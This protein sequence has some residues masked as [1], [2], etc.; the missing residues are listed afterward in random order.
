MQAL[1]FRAL[2][3]GSNLILTRLLFPEAFGLMT[4]VTVFVTGLSMISDVGIRPALIR[5]ARAEDP[6]F[7]STAWSLQILRGLALTALAW[8]LAWPYAAVYDADVLVPLIATAALTTTLAGCASIEV[9]VQERK[10]SIARIVVMHIGSKL[11]GVVATIA[12]AWALGSVWALVWGTLIGAGVKTT[13]SHLLFPSK[14]HRLRWDRDA[15]TEILVFG[16]WVM[17]ATLLAYLGG[18][19]LRAV[20]GA[21][22]DLETLAFLTIAGQFGWMLAGIASSVLRGVAFPALSEIQRKRPED[23]PRL[24]VRLHRILLVCALPVFFGLSLA[25][26]TLIDALYDP[27]YAVAGPLLTL[28]ALNGALGVI[29]MTFSS[30]LLALGDSRTHSVLTGIGAVLRIAGTLAGFAL[31][32]VFGMILGLGIGTTLGT[33]SV[34]WVAERKGVR[35]RLSG[36]AAHGVIYAVYALTLM[37][38]L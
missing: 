1:S 18:Q 9:I 20:E 14:N 29:P 7:Q 3:L 34:F 13:F 30:A 6:V 19:G 11:V 12:L 38:Q 24:A 31:G 33:L 10:L 21:L 15:L 22:V 17:L 36:L 27:R 8:I 26:E 16:R 37:G 4:L 5:S 28:L 23:L 2:Q 25:G 32:G 35:D